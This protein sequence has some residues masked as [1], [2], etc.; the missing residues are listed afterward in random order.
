MMV[1]TFVHD[2]AFITHIRWLNPITT[3]QMSLTISTYETYTVIYIGSTH[4][5]YRLLFTPLFYIA[6]LPMTLISTSI[7]LSLANYVNISCTVLLLFLRFV[8]LIRSRIV[9]F[10]RLSMIENA[11]RSVICVITFWMISCIPYII[12]SDISYK[13]MFNY[14]FCFWPLSYFL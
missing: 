14:K 1:Q 12:F 7:L 10:R 3:L 5:V 13:C 11:H 4:E 9:H 6:L 2:S 8:C